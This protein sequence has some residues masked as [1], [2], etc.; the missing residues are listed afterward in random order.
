MRVLL[1]GVLETFLQS[2]LFKFISKLFLSPC[3]THE[4]LGCCWSEAC[5]GLHLT[6]AFFLGLLEIPYFVCL[7]SEFAIQVLY[8]FSLPFL[9][10]AVSET[11]VSVG[12]Y[13]QFISYRPK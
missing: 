11:P 4:L 8:S 7:N 6:S 9:S 2:F 12:G 3:F 10:L 1:L 13:A 5:T